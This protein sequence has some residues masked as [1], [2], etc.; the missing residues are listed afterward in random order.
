MRTII[1]DVYGSEGHRVDGQARRCQDALAAFSA[2]YGPGPVSLFRAPGRV[3]LIGEH[4]DY[5]QG[6]VLPVA[7]DRDILLLARPR[8]DAQVRLANMEAPY[9]ERAFAIGPAIPPQPLGDW[10]NYAQGPAELL[11]RRTGRPLR[12]LDALVCG[13]P[14][15]GVPRGAGLSSSSALTVAFALALVHV[16]EL[17]LAGAELAVFCS[18]AEWYAGTRGGIMDQFAA[19]LSRRGHALFV[20]CRPEHGRYHTAH[21]PLPSE[22]RLVV[23]DSGERHRNTGPLFNQLVAEVRL[24][25]RMLQERYPGIRSLRDMEGMPWNEYVEDLPECMSLADLR[26]RGIALDELIEGGAPPQA[27]SL[28]VRRRCRHVITENA[29]VLAAV[30]AMQSGD[31]DTLG[32]LMA[33]A[34]A[35][36][37][38]DL[39][40]STPRLDALVALASRFPGVVGARLTGAGWGGCAIALAHAPSAEE[41]A[42]QVARSQPGAQAF[43]AHPAPAAGHLVTINL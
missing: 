39:A 32:R 3:N 26:E 23:M 41:L 6:Y 4:T 20:D 10:G 30:R 5:S 28:Q 40:I 38:D 7:L 36:A 2:H 9:P 29:R 8:S 25:V 35:S 19:L 31:L 43:V 24:G 16:N 14:P 27:D 18:Q 1:Q 13:R 11:A 42:A 34:H 37:R 15:W 17:P 12:G 22:H 33:A 21:A